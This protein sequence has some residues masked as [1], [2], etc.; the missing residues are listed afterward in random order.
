LASV[1][2]PNV[3]AWVA[4]TGA[5]IPPA[6][7]GRPKLALCGTCVNLPNIFKLPEAGGTLDGLTTVTA[8]GDAIVGWHNTNHGRIAAAG[9]SGGC[10]GGAAD[11][12]CPQRSP[13]DPIFYH[14]HHIFDDI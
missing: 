1:G 8:I 13:N 6:H 5:L 9:G 14:Y 2:E 11:I 3:K 7:G 10:L 4:A 12:N